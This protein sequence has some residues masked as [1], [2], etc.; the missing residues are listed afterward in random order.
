MAGPIYNEF[1]TLVGLEQDQLILGPSG[2]K[3]A[4]VRGNRV[5]SLRHAPAGRLV[6]LRGRVVWL[7]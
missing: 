3:I 4:Y 1:G 6:K 5:Y 2:A 7:R